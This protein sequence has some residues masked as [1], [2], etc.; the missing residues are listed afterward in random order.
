MG[1]VQS[2]VSHALHWLWPISASVADRYVAHDVVDD[3]RRHL[4]RSLS[5]SRNKFNTE[6]G[7]FKTAVP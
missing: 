6:F 1:A 5:G 2:H 3:L 4:L 7:L